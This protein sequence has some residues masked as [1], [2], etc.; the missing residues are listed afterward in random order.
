MRPIDWGCT[1][2]SAHDLSISLSRKSYLSSSGLKRKLKCATF[3]LYM[4]IRYAISDLR[5]KDVHNYPAS[6]VQPLDYMPIGYAIFDLRAK[7]V[8]NYP[9]SNMVTATFETRLFHSQELR[10][11]NF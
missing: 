1:F 2:W 10:K 4:P 6:N 5:A 9:A 11:M 8:H 3:R 7:D